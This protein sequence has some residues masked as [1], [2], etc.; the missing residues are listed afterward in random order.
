[1]QLP[2][3]RVVD[4]FLPV[5]WA[6]A[7]GNGL[8]ESG[9]SFEVV[10]NFIPDDLDSARDP[11]DLR[12]N[13][14]PDPGFLLFVGDLS[15]E[16]GVP[17]LLEA[18]GRLR[19]APPLVLIGRACPDTPSSLPPNVKLFTSW[20]HAAILEAWRRA[21]VAIA[22]STWPEPCATVVLE[23]MASGRPVVASDI[24]GMPDLVSHNETGI[25]VRPADPADLA[26]AIDRLLS[27]PD[28]VARM[29]EAGRS[30][31]NL[32]RASTVV[33][34][35]E[36]VYHRLRGA[37]IGTQVSPLATPARRTRLQP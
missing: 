1:M 14:L 19:K 30:R 25:L 21:S 6:T 17:T 35:I 22:P 4:R 15:G 13:E 29:G 31:V 36:S 9:L 26:G 37:E 2:L 7:R 28:L 32:F 12:L 5:S 8:P 27:A 34:R 18:Y 20:P 11:A 33:P 10:P 23:A 16:K 3:R 24:G